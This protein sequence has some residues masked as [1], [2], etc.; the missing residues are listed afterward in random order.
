M[1][2]GKGGMDT[3]KHRK[4]GTVPKGRHCLRSTVMLLNKEAA[5]KKDTDKK[6]TNPT[7]DSVKELFEKE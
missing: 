7:Y 5:K 4:S 1:A 6:K 2:N 3:S